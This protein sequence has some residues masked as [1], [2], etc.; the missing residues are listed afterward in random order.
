M[1]KLFLILFFLVQIPAIF[2]NNQQED[3]SSKKIIGT[4]YTD[5]NRDIKWVFTQ[6]GKLYNYN[7][8][9]Y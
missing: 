7:K 1:K 3:P 2:G 4:W 6:D 8:D 5:A 9:K